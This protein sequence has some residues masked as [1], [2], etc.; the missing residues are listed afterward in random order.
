ML[1]TKPYKNMLDLYSDEANIAG[2][3]LGLGS[4]SGGETAFCVLAALVPS[5]ITDEEYYEVAKNTVATL[6]VLIEKCP[7]ITPNH[8]RTIKYRKSLG[9]GV[10]GLAGLLYKN[11]LDY[12]GSDKSLEFVHDTMERHY[13]ALLTASQELYLD[14]DCSG[15]VQGVD[16]DWLPIDTK[17]SKWDNKLDWGSLR[18]K[19]RLNSVLCSIQPTESSSLV[20]NAEN[21]VYPPRD[22]VVNKKSRKGIVQFIS[23]GFE[24][25][26]NLKAWDVDPVTLSRYY[27]VIQDFTDQGIS[28]DTYFNPDKFD[29]GKKPMSNLVK[30]W[31]AHFRLGNKSMY[32]V[33][34]RDSS[35]GGLQSVMQ[36]EYEEDACTTCTL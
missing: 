23:E 13:H 26:V 3:Q 17:R 22:K 28:A 21:A 34:T 12:D 33:N 30:E 25:G 16:L 10:T 20:S 5:N 4:L 11:G 19:P 18:G 31:V 24:E 6:N 2:H 32:Y 36:K 7:K 29:G 35:G 14:G 27:G 8:N 15:D 1:P 9:V